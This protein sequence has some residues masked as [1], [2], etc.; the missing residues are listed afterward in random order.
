MVRGLR[1]GEGLD[2]PAD[3]WDAP[4]LMTV[5]SSGE[6]VDG[7]ADELDRHHEHL[8]ASGGLAARRRS[9]A[10]EHTRMVLERAMSRRAAAA[11]AEAIEADRD[12]LAGGASPYEVAR[13]IAGRISPP[14]DSIPANGRA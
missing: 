1:P 12:L 10:L 8:D 13:H 9:A 6:G 7:L 14:T 5:A 3:A 11:W 4:I 2:D